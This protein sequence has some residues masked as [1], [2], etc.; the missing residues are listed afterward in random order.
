ME[1]TPTAKGEIKPIAMPGIHQKFLGYF[2]GEN[3]PTDAKIL[4]VGAGHGAFTKR[5]F[6]MGFA[7]EACDLFPEHFY[8]NQVVC[9]KVDITQ[10]FPYPDN[11]FD[12]VVAI[13]VL[14][15]ILD[16]ET[17]FS[18]INRILKPGGRF[19]A[20]TPNILSLKSRMRFLLRGFYYS[21]GPL[22]MNNHDGLQHVVSR[23]L[24]Q[25]DYIAI[26]HGFEAAR[27]EVDRKQSTSRWLMLLIYPF[28]W[29]NH[30]LNKAP[31]IHNN[32]KLLL[33]RVLFLQFGKP[34]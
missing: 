20:S 22:E 31:R 7:V 9:K 8:Y 2:E 1:N 26:K 34:A 5:L 4:D 15:H 24:D 3:I 12:V 16:H 32:L 30:Q 21:F 28:I 11:S 18:E 33:G 23:T 29:L 27:F 14:E 13:E 19:F 6:D 25:Y 17:F 10:Q